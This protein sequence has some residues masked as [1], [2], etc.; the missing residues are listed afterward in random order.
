MNNAAASDQVS[1]ISGPRPSS[2]LSNIALC[3]S[4]KRNATPRGTA[5]QIIEKSAIHYRVHKS[6]ATEQTDIAAG[7]YT[8]IRKLLGSNLARVTDHPEVFSGF[9]QAIRV[10]VGT[11]DRFGHDRFLPNPF[12]IHCS[13]IILSF[14]AILP[15][16]LA[17][18]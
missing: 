16:I 18:M 15:K 1:E 14:G 4:R 13:P 7:L 11:V 3:F 8:C 17:A 12:Q 6:P 9:L 2:T 10:N 5:N